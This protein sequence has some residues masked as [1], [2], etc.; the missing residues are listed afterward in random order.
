MRKE[1]C[2]QMRVGCKPWSEGGL[3]DRE[4][5][6]K[7][8]VTQSSRGEEKGRNAEVSGMCQDFDLELTVRRTAWYF[9]ALTLVE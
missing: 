1:K 2:T 9:H 8:G 3:G 5:R 6:D 4:Q 7:K